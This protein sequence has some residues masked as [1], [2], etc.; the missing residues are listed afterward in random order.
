MN[1]TIGT[2]TEDAR[3]LDKS[4]SGTG[5]TGTLRNECSVQNPSVL[6]RVTASSISGCNYMYISE[7]GRYYFITD[8]T[9][10]SDTLSM[11]SG[12]CD[13]LKTYA[14]GIRSNSCILKRSANLNEPFINDGSYT[15][16]SQ[17]TT[18]YY[19]FPV[20]FPD[21]DNIILITV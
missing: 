17:M 16:K 10:V 5:Y 3:C 2:V 4:F 12:R 7:F 13:V 18:D 11:V 20:F 6:M 9:A 8:I 19:P 21:A 1:V 15:M 14:A